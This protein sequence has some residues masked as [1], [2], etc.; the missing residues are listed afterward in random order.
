MKQMALKAGLSTAD[1]GQGKRLTNT[2]AR[3]A[4]CQKLIAAEI[5]DTRAIHITG[6]KNPSSLNNYRTLTN[7]QQ[8]EISNLLA[9]TAP[10]PNV[11]NDTNRQSV[12]ILSQ[13]H[14]SSVRSSC[15]QVP[16]LFNNCKIT[17]GVFNISFHRKRSHSDTESDESDD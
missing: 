6:H 1:Q 5:P 16:I 8:R 15:S 9:T 17:G 13:S 11:S 10:V 12:E 7:V 2:S 4:L 3:K 14:T